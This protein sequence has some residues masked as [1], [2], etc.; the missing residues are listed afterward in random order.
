MYC[1]VLYC[2]PSGAK[3]KSMKAGFHVIHD[4]FI[5]QTHSSGCY[6]EKKNIYIYIYILYTG[7]A[8]FSM[9]PFRYMEEEASHKN[10]DTGLVDY[11]DYRV[12]NSR[13]HKGRHQAGVSGRKSRTALGPEEIH[14]WLN[15]KPPVWEIFIF[16]FNFNINLNFSGH[17]ATDEQEGTMIN[18]KPN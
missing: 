11:P 13:H 4:S 8:L 14:Y 18:C 2:I 3:T 1:T 5:P 15:M 6:A 9:D 17:Q 7:E 12:R 10:T 16:T